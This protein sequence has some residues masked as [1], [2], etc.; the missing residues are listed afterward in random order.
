MYTTATL[1]AH[2]QA[3]QSD[4]PTGLSMSSSA[5]DRQGKRQQNQGTAKCEDG[6]WYTRLN[7]QPLLLTL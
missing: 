6:D 5:R 1:A 7:N 3:Q 2:C 4:L